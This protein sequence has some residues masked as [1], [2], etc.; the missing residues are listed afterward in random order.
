MCE[1]LTAVFIFDA[2]FIIRWVNIRIR[3]LRKPIRDNPK[4][5]TKSEKIF[6]KSEK[7]FQ[8]VM[9]IGNHR[10]RVYQI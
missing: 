8:I 1:T 6:L 4:I 5:F 3:N 7:I 10:W 2:P 9:F